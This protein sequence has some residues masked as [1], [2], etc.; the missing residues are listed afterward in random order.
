MWFFTKNSFISIVQHR[1]QPDTVLVR[2]RVKKHLE[3][4]F[5][6]NAEKI[7]ADNGA[8]YKHRLEMNKKEL[9]EV[10]SAYILHNLEYDNF[11]ASQETDTPSW[12]RFL[13]AVWAE[14]LKL[15]K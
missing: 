3:R 10:V 15:Q 11:K 12:M 4:L 6:H 5:P 1:E 2:A 8:D 9:A 14:G 13:H 7:Y